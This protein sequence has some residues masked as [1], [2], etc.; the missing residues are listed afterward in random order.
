MERGNQELF[1]LRIEE[2][3]L[4]NTTVMKD[5]TKV[6][7]KSGAVALGKFLIWTLNLFHQINGQERNH[8]AYE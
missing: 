4:P 2:F 5:I 3:T 8:S 1:Q 7:L 6:I